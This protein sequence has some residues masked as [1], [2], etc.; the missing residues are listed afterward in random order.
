MT[1]WENLKNLSVEE[2]AKKMIIVYEK[3]GEQKFLTSD[4]KTFLTE[5][6]AIS[7]EIDWLMKE[8]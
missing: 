2:F 1:N 4:D 6:S 5:N 3:N 7:Y 8:V